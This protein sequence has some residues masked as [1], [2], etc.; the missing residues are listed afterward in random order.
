MTAGVCST[1][2]RRLMTIW[3]TRDRSRVNWDSLS[4]SRGGLMKFMPRLGIS[5]VSEAV[6]FWWTPSVLISGCSPWSWLCLARV[7]TCLF[8]ILLGGGGLVWEGAVKA[9]MLSAHFDGKQSMDPIDLPFTWN[10]STSL[11]TYPFRSREVGRLLL[12]LYSYG[13]T[14]PVSMFRL[15]LKSTA[16]VLATRLAV[17]F[18]RLIRLGSFPLCW[19][20]ANVTQIPKG[21]PSSVANYWP[22]SLTPILSKFFER[23]VSVRLGRFMEC[24]GALTTTQFAYRKCLGTCDVLLCVA[25]S[26]QSALVTGQEAWMVQ[27]DF[28][29]AFDRVNHR[30]ILFKLCSVGV[31]GSVLSVLTQCLSNWS[32]DVMVDGCF[33][34]LINVVPGVPLGCVLGLQLF[35]LYTAELFSIVEN[36]F[37]GYAD[38]HSGSC[39]AIPCWERLLQS[40]WIS[41]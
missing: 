39:C 12:D 37:Y 30:G 28:S 21:P 32:Q 2:S 19:R 11:T 25:H 36:K 34:K 29:A 20:V 31:G 23:L 38:D 14:E 16:V 7:R 15:F 22:I 10:P 3:W 13:G 18:R 8:P 1:S 26:L 4:I 40:L 9:E 33:S 41:I 6:M 24:R 5:L 17:V 27:I 35:L